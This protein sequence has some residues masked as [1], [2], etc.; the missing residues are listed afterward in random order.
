MHTYTNTMQVQVVYHAECKQKLF[1]EQ[2]EFSFT[3]RLT[4]LRKSNITFFFSRF[5]FQYL[6]LVFKILNQ[7]LG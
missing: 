1:S 6:F 3:S 7:F 2:P 4:L 5:N